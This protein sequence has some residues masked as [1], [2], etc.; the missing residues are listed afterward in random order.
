MDVWKQSFE[1]LIFLQDRSIGLKAIIA[2]HSTKL[3]LLSADAGCGNT[4]ATKTPFWMPYD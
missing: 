3:V 2:I 1:Q 4:P